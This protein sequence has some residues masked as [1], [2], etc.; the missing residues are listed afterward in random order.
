MT[1][2]QQGH[3]TTT[4]EEHFSYPLT[5]DYNFTYAPDYS[6]GTQIFSVNQQ[7]MHDVSTGFFGHPNY[8]SHVNEQTAGQDQLDFNF[9][10]QTF[11][12]QGATT[13]QSYRSYANR[14]N[15]YNETLTA[16][17]NVLTGVSQT[18]ACSNNH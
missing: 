17:N 15:C 2:T 14:G 3:I 7:Y 12:T 16:A 8:T 10:T 6:G 13:S 18:P 4:S 11:T 9:N 1:S 5:I